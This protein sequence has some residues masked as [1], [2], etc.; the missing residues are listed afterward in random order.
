LDLGAWQRLGVWL[1]TQPTWRTRR[2]QRREAREPGYAYLELPGCALRYRDHGE[3]DDCYVFAA[4]PPIV[5]EHYDELV[6]VLSRQ[7]RV[8]VLEL[9]GFGFSPARPGFDFELGSTVRALELALERL[10]LRG[11]TLCFPCASAYVALAL[12]HARP[13]LVSRLLL[14]QAPAYAGE[15]AWKQRRDPRGVL[16]RPV[17]GQL[18]MRAISKSRLPAWFALSVGDRERLRPFTELAAERLAAGA[19]WSLA[20][21]FQRYLVDGVAPPQVEQPLLALWGE[22]D[23]SHQGT[24]FESSR[25]LS[26]RTELVRWKDVGH[27][28]ELEAPERFVELLRDGPWPTA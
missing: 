14:A 17:S 16:G 15:L 11:V 28:P 21:A 9:P 27:F 2:E 19:R 24:D 10:G 23:R 8:I 20:S 25:S 12:A 4:D 6:G 5:L 22:R 3:G 26:R 1:D 13:E 7:A 18:A